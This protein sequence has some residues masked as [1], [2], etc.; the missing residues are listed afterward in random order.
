M[1]SRVAGRLT[2]TIRN[3]FGAS[4]RD[5]RARG[6]RL[7][8]R[9]EALEGRE[10][11]T[12]ASGV[13]SFASAA[14]LHPMKVNVLK[15][16]PGVSLNP[17]F[18]APYDQS[19][20]PSILVGQTGP[21]IM[22]TAGNPIWFRPFSNNNKVQVLDFRTQTLYGKPVLIWWQGQIAGIVKSSSPAGTS[23]GGHFVIYDQHYR[24][25]MDV[26][27]PGGSSMDLHEL[28][29]TPQG[30]A[31]F[32]T[33]KR[34]RADL[35]P[36]GGARNGQ[37]VD[38]V[39]QGINLR[40]GRRVF[41][42]DMAAHIPLGDSVVPVT[43]GKPWDPYHV[44]S[45]DVSP[46][47]SQILISSRNTWA[48]NAISLQSGQV[49]WQLGGKRNEFRLPTDLVTGPYGSAFQYQHDAR[50]VPGG[51]SLYDNAGIGA[52]PNA[53]PFGP[54]RGL[55]LNLDIPNRAAGLAR[56]ATYHDPAL[57]ANSQG[58]FQVLAN[59]GA[60][61]GW[62]SE[63]QPGEGLSS[64]YTAYAADGSVLAD[65]VLAGQDISYR[66][67]TLPWVG[68]PLTKPSLAVAVGGGGATV[69]ASWNGSTE[70]A[71]WQ[72]LAGPSRRSLVPVAAA[73]RTG[74][75]TTIPAASAGPFF[76]V[77]ALDAGGRVL[78]TSAVLR[79]RG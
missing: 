6:R 19:P 66:A 65:Y 20:D 71:S 49:L 41:A 76:Q 3:I 51:I 59:G 68:L 24:K 8:P 48:I 40:T 10:L 46:D 14:K 60:F 53:G 21:L 9:P 22:D 2:R 35:T 56:P 27:P 52:P 62:G 61:V 77:R 32:I 18:V 33:T 63:S 44:N 36:Y 57:Y 17:V 50:Y 79:V 78:G 15:L 39:I 73:S 5:S 42:W 4:H 67:Y 69:A 29:I 54:A 25:I 1:T 28:T 31:F 23:V 45:I 75:E 12:G 7:A 37:F 55:I 74:F 11:L 26:R 30:T 47:G 38:A 16:Q 64:Y 13:W 34:V 58:N 72:V 70:T 43:P